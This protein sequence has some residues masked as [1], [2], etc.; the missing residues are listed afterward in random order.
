MGR[1]LEQW[2]RTWI[3][4]SRPSLKGEPLLVDP[5]AWWCHRC[6]ASI[7]D[8]VLTD[9]GCP[10]C[11]GGPGVLDG[12]IRLGSYGGWL[13]D[14][15]S[16]LKY[17]GWWEVARP[18]GHLL[19]E[20]IRALHDLSPEETIVVPMPMPR[21]RRFGRGVDHAWLLASH[22]A[23][24]LGLPCRQVLLKREGRPQVGSSFSQ[25]REA[26]TGSIQPRRN[27]GISRRGANLEGVSIV[28]IDDVL[29]SGRTARAAGK[30]LRSMGSRRV[31]LGTLA[32]TGS[33]NP[34]PGLKGLKKVIQAS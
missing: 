31:I 21:W 15:I 3:G 34:V 16:A 10:R 32:V 1:L 24:S 7:V 5:A 17:E 19:G 12:V 22:A 11:R 2:A 9:E 18:L 27:R 28:L 14:A 4:C 6:G 33:S 8:G 29:T 30:C 26:G 23:R 13:R 20:R 25:R